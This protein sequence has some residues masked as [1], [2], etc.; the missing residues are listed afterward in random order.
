M[1]MI[2]SSRKESNP[3]RICIAGDSAGGGLAIATLL[4]LREKGIP[5]PAGVFCFSPWLD[6]TLSGNSVTTNKDLDPILSGSI[7]REICE[8]LYWQP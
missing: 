7:L 4:A 2:G 1:L 5:L 8:L 3:S 6:L